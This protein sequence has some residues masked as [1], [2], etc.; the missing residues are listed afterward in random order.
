MGI[1]CLCLTFMLVSCALIR[2]GDV[3]LSAFLID[4]LNISH[5][6]LIVLQSYHIISR[7]D[8]YRVALLRRKFRE[9]VFLSTQ[10]L[11]QIFLLPR[12]RV[13]PVLPQILGKL[14][15][16]TQQ[17][18]PNRN[19]QIDAVLLV[20]IQNLSDSQNLLTNLW[21]VHYASH[22]VLELPDRRILEYYQASLVVEAEG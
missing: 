13:Q 1:G 11:C 16:L 5:N 21:L 9:K 10:Q 17:I 15:R 3:L 19:L 7:N 4:F 18:I 22:L 8:L 20:R 12:I 6:H 14:P 2:V